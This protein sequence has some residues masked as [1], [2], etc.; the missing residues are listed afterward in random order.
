MSAAALVA[1][2]RRQ[3]AHAEAGSTDQVASV[4]QVPARNYLDPARWQAEMDLI[5]K[6]LPLVLGFSGELA[7]PGD[8]R[9]LDACGV[10]ILLVRGADGVARG[11]FNVCSHRGAIVVEAGSG[12]ARRFTCPY[13]G[14]N[15]DLGGTL[16][17]VRDRE[18]FGEID[19]SCNG[20]TPLA[21]SE[22]AGLIFGSIT[23]GVSVDID[24]YLCG[25]DSMLEHLSFGQCHVVGAQTVVGP[26]W[27]VAYDGYLDL[28]HLPILHR[29]TFG[30]EISNK[31]LYDVWGPHQRVTSPSLTPGRYRDLPD[32]EWPIEKI[33]G[34]VWTIFP[35]VSVASFEADGRVHMVSRL[36]PG[37]SVGESITVQTFL[38]T[39]EPTDER[40]ESVAKTMD[41]LR[42][43]VEDEDYYTGLRVQRA[44]ASGAKD[45]VM[46]GRNEGGGQRF[47]RWVDALL[48]AAD[49]ADLDHLLSAGISL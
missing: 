47:H 48:D 22:R 46:F 5:F 9:S 10:P 32:D 8:Y 33:N 43:V 11:F 38:H 49:P 20:L 6:R 27:K 17:G 15:Y 25:Y 36:F 34:G 31:S 37:A 2:A 26:N 40:I 19:T 16:V 1:T 29:N 7:A 13:H 18:M 30:T 24:R 44:L 42:H 41:F 35:H 14:W 28:Y 4:L 23:P 12:N 3:L 39:Q 45:S 21:V